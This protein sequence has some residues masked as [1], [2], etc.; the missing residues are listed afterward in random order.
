MINRKTLGFVLVLSFFLHISTFAFAEGDSVIDGQYFSIIDSRNPISEYQIRNRKNADLTGDNGGLCNVSAITTLLNRRLAADNYSGTFSVTNVFQSL[1][2]KN[3]KTDGKLYSGKNFET[4]G[5][6]WCQY[7]YFNGS[8][9]SWCVSGT[10]YSNGDHTYTVTQISGSTVK[11]S[12]SKEN[13][14]A[15]IANLLHQHPEGIA[16]RNTTANHVVVIYKYTYS[17]GIYTLYVKDPVFNYSGTIDGSYIGGLVNNDL[18]TNIDFLV[19]L[20]GTPNVITNSSQSIQT[21]HYTDASKKINI[22]SQSG[23]T[24]SDLLMPGYSDHTVQEY[25][26]GLYSIAHAVQWLS[27]RYLSDSES[28]QLMQKLVDL[29]LD[30][31]GEG[32][33]SGVT[34]GMTNCLNKVVSTDMTLVYHQGV[35]PAYNTPDKSKVISIFDNGGVIIANPIHH[36]VLAVGYRYYNNELYIQIVDS[37]TYST[38]EPRSGLTLHTGYYYGSMNEIKEEQGGKGSQYW[39]SWNCFSGTCNHTERKFRNWWWLSGYSSTL[40]D[41][42]QTTPDSPTLSIS[43]ETYPSGHRNEGESMTLKGIITSNETI[44]EVFGSL[45]D[46]TTNELIDKNI[47]STKTNPCVVNPNAT[48][49][50]LNSNDFDR[51]IKIGELPDGVFRYEVK[52]TTVSGYSKVLI[53]SIFT[54]GTGN[55]PISVYIEC[56]D[57]PIYD[58]EGQYEIGTSVPIDAYVYPDDTVGVT[59]KSS[60]PSVAAV[61]QDGVLEVYGYGTSVISAHAKTNENI[62]AKFT[63]VCP[64]Y[65]YTVNNRKATITKYVGNESNVIIPTNLFGYEVTEIG[66][67]AFHQCHSLKSITIPDSVKIIGDGAFSYCDELTTVELPFFMDEIQSGAFYGCTKL[68]S[69]QIPYGIDCIDEMVFGVCTSLNLSNSN[70]PETVKKV[71]N[72]AFYS[73]EKLTS[74]SFANCN[75]LEIDE[76]AFCNCNILSDVMFPKG[77]T[78]IADT[79]FYQSN[80][81]KFYCHY[82]TVAYQYALDN[83][84]SYELLG[85]KCGDNL[86]WDLQG[87]TLYIIGNGNMYDY[88]QGT[89]PWQ[90][91]AAQITSIEVGAGVTS[92]GQYAFYNC[93]NLTQITLHE[94]LTY[95]AGG[96]FESCTALNNVY[97]P[98]S[99]ISLGWYAFGI[100]RSLNTIRFSPNITEIG[101][102]AFRSTAITEFGS[103]LNKLSYIGSDCFDGSSIVSVHLPEGL[104]NLYSRTFEDCHSLTEVYIPNS[105]SSIEDGCFTRAENVV[106][107]CSAGSVAHQFA[108]SNNIPYELIGCSHPSTTRVVLKEANCIEDGQWGERC[109]TCNEII[110]SGSIPALGHDWGDWIETIAATC[111]ANGVE[112]RSCKRDNSH[113]ET[114]N[115]DMIAHKFDQLVTKTEPTCTESGE[116]IFICSVCGASGPVVMPI[117]PLGHSGQW[118]IAKEATEQKEGLRENRCTR[119]NELLESEIIP[120]KT[121]AYDFLIPSAITV[122]EE[123]AF[124]GI[125]AKSVKLS[126]NVTEI[127]RLA[128]ANCGKLEKIYIPESTRTIHKDAFF[129]VTGLTIYGYYNSYAKTYAK[130]NGIAFVAI[131]EIKP[132]SITGQGAEAVNVGQTVTLSASLTPNNVNNQKI[133]WASSDA[134]LGTVSENGVVTGLKRGTVTITATADADPSLSFSFTITVRQPITITFDANGGSCQEGSR[135]AYAEYALGS[136]LPVAT[137]TYYSFDGWFTERSGG[138]RVTASDSFNADTTL[139][140]HWTIDTCSISFDANGGSCGTASKSINKGDAVGTLP[141]PERTYYSFDGWFTANGTPVSASTTFT[142]NTTLYAYWER[143]TC[144]IYFDANGGSCGI[145]SVTIYRGDAVNGGLPFAT[146]PYYTYGG[147]YTAAG[148][149]MY[150]SSVFTEDITLYTHWI[151]NEWSDW[152]VSGDKPDNARVVDSKTQYS[153]RDQ[154]ASLSYG[155]W[156][157]WTET[158]TTITDSTLMNEETAQKY[159]WWAAQCTSCGR[160]NPYHGSSSKCKSCG[161]TLTGSAYIN[162]LY[163]SDDSTGSSIDGRSN[164]RNYNGKP[165]WY[166]GEKPT[167]YRYRTNTYVYS[168][169]GWSAWSDTAVTATSTREVQT[170]TMIRYQLP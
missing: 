106:I 54:V 131:D 124:S 28:K 90:A 77:I 43:D 7:Y 69:I 113:T 70:I 10:T 127:E 39:I 98:D 157:E 164:G 114:R 139:F 126:E 23:G 160:N 115:V 45:Y 144:T 25:G 88:A 83:S 56:G 156:G 71:G 4:S 34:K 130:E 47:F 120:K 14:N 128:F 168:W 166:T 136:E 84:I 78:S 13:F 20:N 154:S 1:G 42:I 44:T 35:F 6:K 19:Y 46:D 52:A 161:K 97:L 116:Q 73:C 118:I 91:Y 33:G 125:S 48:S 8:T 132:D 24:F 9:S 81:T 112:T 76:Y 167:V 38:I 146:R 145:P 55:A 66:A 32:S 61:S 41:S 15:Y 138:S 111:T 99:V 53:D 137:R 129:G 21:G 133:N 104:T 87:S 149:R 169:G 62:F 65:E 159:K 170:R 155:E 11:N 109:N 123:D 3:I 96:A 2:C 50:N 64:P 147:W 75:T 89:A 51:K 142:E 67:N 16:I 135:S 27:N 68:E 102:S 26:C 162:V 40:L 12:T 31:T 119:C 94:G 22:R 122:I 36:Y 141:T 59:W 105:V 95:I 29:Q 85:S 72:S 151:D 153:Y 117:D 152:V 148:T 49:Y 150:D 74:I 101:F 163:Y 121:V 60:N 93:T 17:N 18:Y 143:Q 79:A 80:N 103:N 57:T 134:S 107:Y 110:E 158:R 63:V 30:T 58:V 92:I 108:I 100:C 82:D 37:S 165:Y 5:T 86:I 140:A